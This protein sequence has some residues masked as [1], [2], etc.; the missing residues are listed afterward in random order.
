MVR[1]PTGASQYSAILFDTK[2]SKAVVTTLMYIIRQERPTE[3]DTSAQ[4]QELCHCHIVADFVSLMTLNR[5]YCHSY[6]ISSITFIHLPFSYSSFPFFHVLYL[7]ISFVLVVI[8]LLF[9]RYL[10]CLS[11][12]LL[13][14]STLCLRSL[15][16]T[17]LLNFSPCFV[18]VSS[19]FSLLIYSLFHLFYFF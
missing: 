4:L 8:P 18:L 17:H 19:T 12:F 10:F 16:L 5:S 7:C 1:I 6:I 9:S 2:M 11:F 15:F 14:Y 13:S 3:L